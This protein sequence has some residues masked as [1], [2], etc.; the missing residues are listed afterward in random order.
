MIRFTLD[1]EVAAFAQWR[2]INEKQRDRQRD[3]L[4]R[5]KVLSYKGNLFY[6]FFSF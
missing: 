3:L 6:Q 1:S 5:E 4:R 2:A